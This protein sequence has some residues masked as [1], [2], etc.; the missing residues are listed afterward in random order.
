MQIYEHVEG[1]TFRRLRSD[2]DYGET[3]SYERDESVRVTGAS[4]FS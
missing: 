3:L 1:D 2:G 4:H